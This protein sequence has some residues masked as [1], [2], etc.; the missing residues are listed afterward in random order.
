MTSWHLPLE[1]IVCED[2]TDEVMAAYRARGLALVFSEEVMRYDLTDSLPQIN[3]PDDVVYH[4]WESENRQA[5][6]AVYEAAFRDRPGFPAWR[7]EQWLSWVADD[8]TFRPDLS[9][10]AT[11]GDEA[12]GF[13]T[14]TQSEE[15]PHHTGYLI[16][17]GVTP[18]WRG[19]GLGAALTL[20]SLQAWRA[21]GKVAMVL[22]VNSNNPGALRLYRRLGFVTIKRRG[23]FRPA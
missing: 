17:V 9:F 10:L 7:A 15:D 20:R 22:H 19:Q 1:E 13:V 11:C 12:I 4:N 21:D 16:Q 6:F 14:N 3:S 18:A 2:V 8:P 5:F 23:K